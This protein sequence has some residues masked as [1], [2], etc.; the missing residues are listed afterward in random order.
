M[1]RLIV[2]YTDGTKEEGIYKTEDEARTA[3]KGFYKA[4]GR[5]IA[6]T[7]IKKGA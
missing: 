2:W 1:Y 3:E 6:G 4:F 5:Q 7:T